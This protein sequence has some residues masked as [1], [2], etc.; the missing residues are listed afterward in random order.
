M[1]KNDELQ[2]VA[3]RLTKDQYSKLLNDS[4][5]LGLSSSAYMR[6]LI[7]NAKID[8]KVDVTEVDLKKA[9]NVRL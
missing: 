4:K 5:N 8:I 2:Y 3:T 1:D 9:S 7:V 6:L